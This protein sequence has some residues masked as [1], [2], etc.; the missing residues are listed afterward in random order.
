[1]SSGDDGSID[2]NWS[3][4]RRVHPSQIVR[5]DNAGVTRVSSGAFRDAEMSVDA[6]EIWQA[7]GQ[8]WHSSLTGYPG[9][10][11]VRFAAALPRTMGLA[12][13]HLPLAT[14]PAHAEVHGKKT[15]SIRNRFVA[16]STWVYLV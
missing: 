14:N 13:I 12:V 11:L 5:D 1:M 15:G 6:E 8:D 3:L 9:Y 10:S 2:S 7:N 4:L 16:E